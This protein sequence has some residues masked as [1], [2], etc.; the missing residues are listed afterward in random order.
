MGISVDMDVWPYFLV[1][2]IVCFVIDHILGLALIFSGLALLFFSIGVTGA[3]G[4]NILDYD[5]VVE[6]LAV[7]IFTP[8]FLRLFFVLKKQRIPGDGMVG[9]KTNDLGS[10]KDRNAEKIYKGVVVAGKFL[11]LFTFH[12]V[13][14]GLAIVS[15]ATIL[16]WIKPEGSLI[17][18][19]VIGCPY[20]A[21]FVGD[22]RGA[23]G[24]KTILWA[25]GGLVFGVVYSLFVTMATMALRL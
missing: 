4:I 1:A 5:V 20:A 17:A 10:Y 13:T 23:T 12:F 3:V 11:P 18:L 6:L 7:F 15:V 25:F 24:L 22:T 9:A 16:G 19:A 2:A 8:I 14:G 21:S